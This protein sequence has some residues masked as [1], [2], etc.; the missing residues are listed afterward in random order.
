MKIQ[1]SDSAVETVQ[2]HIEEFGEDITVED[3]VNK[4][5]EGA[6]EEGNLVEDY[7]G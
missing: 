5:I 3:L 6:A 4:I 1:L 2:L 7:A